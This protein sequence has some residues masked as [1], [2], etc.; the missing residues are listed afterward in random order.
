MPT[1]TLEQIDDWIADFRRAEHPDAPSPQR[2]DDDFDGT[3]IDTALVF[4]EWG[5]ATTQAYLRREIG[6][7]PDW[8]ITLL[9]RDEATTLDSDE[10][11]ELAGQVARL[12]RLGAFLTRRTAD[13]L[14]RRHAGA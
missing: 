1:V 6:V 9:P 3:T 4:I 8:S 7:S 12:A 5:P 11:L 14:R 13:H 2:S 10:A